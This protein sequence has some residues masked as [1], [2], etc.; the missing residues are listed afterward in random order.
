MGRTAYSR[1]FVTAL[2]QLAFAG[3]QVV[4]V[5]QVFGPVPVTAVLD[6][7]TLIVGS[8]VGPRIVRLIGIDAPEPGQGGARGAAFGAQ[9]TAYLSTILPPGT[10]VWLEL[11][12][13][14]QDAYGRLLAYLYVESS[15]GEWS[16]QGA[17]VDQV[18]LLMVQAGLATVMTIAPNGAY[19]DLYEAGLTQ[20]RRTGLGM[21]AP[22]G[23][24][25]AQ[26]PSVLPIQLHCALYNPATPNDEN[27]EWVSVMLQERFDTTGFYLY[28]EGSSSVFVLP[29][30]TQ[31]PGEIRVR[32]SGQGVWNNGGD[33]IYLKRGA[34]IVDTWDYSTQLAPQGR[35]IC[36]GAQQ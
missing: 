9:A 1:L 14:T 27:G 23:P 34:L 30:G 6:G 15:W 29:S 32:N 5:G 20:A 28:D 3:A 21:W 22:A 24:D 26:Q 16:L 8:N 18:N 12:R 36:R 4:P 11:D 35:V 2:A 25:L 31:E 13:G 19:A 10:P 17:R 7:D 33:V